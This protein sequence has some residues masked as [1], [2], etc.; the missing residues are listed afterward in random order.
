MRYFQELRRNKRMKMYLKR[1]MG[2]NATQRMMNLQMKKRKSLKLTERH[3]CQRTAKLHGPHQSET[4]TRSLSFPAVY[5]KQASKLWH[6][7]M[8]AL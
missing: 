3:F 8:G 2:K 7:N 6:Q 5:A 1:K 4:A